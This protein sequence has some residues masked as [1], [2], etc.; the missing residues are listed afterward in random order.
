MGLGLIA[1]VLLKMNHVR[2]RVT[3]LILIL[4][5]LFLTTTIGIIAKTHELNLNST[6]GVIDAGKVYVG[7]LANGFSNVKTIVGN[8]I[9]MDW[10][11]T[12]EVNLFNNSK[13]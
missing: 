5:G 11:S 10:R 3:L 9:K 1:A 8:A 6:D 2:H 7:W 12:E 13:K 4:L